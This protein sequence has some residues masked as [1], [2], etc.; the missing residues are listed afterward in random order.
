[1]RHQYPRNQAD[2]EGKEGVREMPKCEG[3]PEGWWA[4]TT[5]NEV[6]REK[7]SSH[8]LNLL[9]SLPFQVIRQTGFQRLAD[10][11]IWTFAAFE[12]HCSLA[13]KHSHS[14]STIHLPRKA[15]WNQTPVLLQPFKRPDWVL[16]SG[17][18]RNICVLTLWQSFGIFFLFLKKSYSGSQRYNQFYSYTL[19]WGRRG[20][21]SRPAGPWASRSHSTMRT[22]EALISLEFYLVFFV[23]HLA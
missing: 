17:T 22:A 23:L 20:V 10:C 3:L 12:W 7:L 19:L 16:N 15:G 4:N 8:Q 14:T 2:W 1:M 13:Y 21:K 18:P 6:S 5:F 11:M 9:V